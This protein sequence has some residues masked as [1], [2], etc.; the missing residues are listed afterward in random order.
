MSFSSFPVLCASVA[1]VNDFVA[2]SMLTIS[3]TGIN[4]VSIVNAAADCEFLDDTDTH[5]G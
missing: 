5:V 2:Y 3:G 1:N 4:G